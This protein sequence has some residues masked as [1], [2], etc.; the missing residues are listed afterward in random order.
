MKSGA[1]GKLPKSVMKAARAVRHHTNVD[2]LDED[3][4]KRM[5]LAVPGAKWDSWIQ[6]HVFNCTIW[7]DGTSAKGT[8]LS[9]SGSDCA[10]ER[11]M[12]MATMLRSQ[13]QE[14]AEMGTLGRIS[15]TY[16]V[17]YE[18]HHVSGDNIVRWL[19]VETGEVSEPG[20]P[21]IEAEEERLAKE[22]GVAA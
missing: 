22:S 14:W 18:I 2:L 20:R 6:I 11:A 16:Q 19:D 17:V 21:W 1:S 7:G 15:T 4:L 10:I 12:I 9:T 5:V 3:R 8:V 13:E